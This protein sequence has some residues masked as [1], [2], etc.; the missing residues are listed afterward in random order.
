MVGKIR[1]AITT[2]HKRLGNRKKGM[3]E[4]ALHDNPQSRDQEK[5]DTDKIEK[6]ILLFKQRRRNGK[7]EE[8][9]ISLQNES[10]ETSGLP[11]RDISDGIRETPL[12]N[13]PEEAR[14]EPIISSQTE[15]RETSGIQIG[16][17]HV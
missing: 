4:I 5:T 6:A 8:T 12:Q 11:Q 3:S 14:E 15:S 9:E 13:S 10:E 1:Q 2:F 7:K 16:R 17:A